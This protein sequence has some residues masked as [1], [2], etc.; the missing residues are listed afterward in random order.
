MVYCAFE[1][2]N[3]YC[4]NKRIMGFQCRYAKFFGVDHSIASRHSHYDCGNDP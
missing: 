1:H 4:C 2:G 3:D